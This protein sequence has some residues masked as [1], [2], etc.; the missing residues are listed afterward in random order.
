VGEIREEAEGVPFWG[1][2]AAGISEAAGILAGRMRRRSDPRS[3][4]SGSS[5]GLARPLVA[6]GCR[7]GVAK[8]SRRRGDDGW[9]PGGGGLL[10]RDPGGACDAGR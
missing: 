7:G 10:L 3:T 2:L 8:A 9:L 4:A 6:I 5:A 1:L